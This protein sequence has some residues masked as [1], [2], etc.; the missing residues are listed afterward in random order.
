MLCALTLARECHA[1]TRCAATI[2][3]LRALVADPSFP[4]E[5]HETTMD[6]GRPLVLSILEKDGAL[7]LKFFK[8]REGLWAESLTVV[9][10]KDARLEARFA[11]EQ[12]RLGPA[13]H[14]ATRFS[15]GSGARFTLT[16]LGAEQ[17][18][19]TAPGWSGMFAPHERR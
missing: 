3:D 15:F 2:R 5:W 9:C 16:R 4:L 10:E 12:V 7:F 13:A 11:E 18:R 19:I 1:A 8:A 17:L 6:D 14:W